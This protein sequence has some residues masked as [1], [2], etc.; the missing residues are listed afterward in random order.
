MKPPSPGVGATTGGATGA[1]AEG[2]AAPPRPLPPPPPRPAPGT[3]S[4]NPMGSS[5]DTMYMVPFAGSTAEL[6]QLAPP[7]LPGICTVPFRL[8]GVNKPSLRQVWSMVLTWAFS[9]SVRYGLIS[10]SV[11]DCRAKGGGLVG[12]GCVGQDSSPGTSDCG[13]L[14]SSIGQRGSPVTRL[15]TN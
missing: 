4:V 13:T 11:K 3:V 15:S 10:F 9:S 1:G 6:P 7:L 5:F 14:R 12:K 8:G 2:G